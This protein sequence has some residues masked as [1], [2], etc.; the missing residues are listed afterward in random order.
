M[1]SVLC[2]A[3]SC[4]KENPTGSFNFNGQTISNL[5]ALYY[6]S[7]GEHYNFAFVSLDVETLL[8]ELEAYLPGP[9]SYFYDRKGIN[10]C[11]VDMEASR[12]GKKLDFDDTKV[13]HSFVYW[14]INEIENSCSSVEVNDKGTIRVDFNPS[15]E[16]LSVDVDLTTVYDGQEVPVTLTYRGIARQVS[17]YIWDYVAPM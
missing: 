3:V 10:I 1:A 5:E 2:L 4:E 11:S 13:G 12:F 9:G 16:M 15:N 17:E 8:P 6:T 14:R 7:T